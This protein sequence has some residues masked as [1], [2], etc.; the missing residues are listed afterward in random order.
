[1]IGPFEENSIHCVDAYEAIKRIPDKSID[2]IYTDIPYLYQQGGSGSSELGERTAKKR[3]RLMGYDDSRAALNGM[4][5]G[6]MLKQ[7]KR[8]EREQEGQS[9]ENGIDYAR[10]VNGR[11]SQ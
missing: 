8:G 11:L 7:A 2:C 5:Y 3:L 1:M 4:T 6:E 9:I 10:Q